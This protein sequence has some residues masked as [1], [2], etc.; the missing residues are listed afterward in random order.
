M[1]N[2][3]IAYAGIQVGW[4]I[5]PDR[6]LKDDISKSDLGL[7]FINKIN[8]VSYVRI[9]D[10]GQKTEYGFIAREL[11]ETLISL[12]LVNN[13]MITKDDAGMYSVR[14][15]DQFAPIVKAM[16]EQQAIIKD[17]KAKIN[18]LEEQ[19]RQLENRLQIIE[20]KLKL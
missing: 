18:T 4:S 2:Y 20:E 16:H 5:T 7:E 3:V 8:P 17:G 10:E 15:N 13:G 9:I 19:N 1:G 14:Y 12:G 6:R 11:E